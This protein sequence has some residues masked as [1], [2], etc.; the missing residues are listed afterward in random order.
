[1]RSAPSSR[2]R[3][4]SARPPSMRARILG[5]VQAL[6]EDGL[7]VSVAEALDAVAAVAAAGVDRAVLREALAATLVKDEADRPAFD[8]RFDTMFPARGA[9]PARPRK[10]RARRRSGRR[11]RRRARARGAGA[12][13]S[14]PRGEATSRIGRGRRRRRCRERT[15]AERRGEAERPSPRAARGGASSRCRSAS[16]RRSTRGGA[17]GGRELAARLRGRLARRTWRT[18]RGRLDF[19]RTIRSSIAPAACRCGLRF[20]ARRPGR[21]DLVVLCDLSRSVAEASGLLLALLAPLGRYFR[22]VELFAYV[23]RLCPVTL[24]GGHVVPDGPPRP[25]RALGPRPRAGGAGCARAACRSAARRSCLVLGDARNNRLPPRADLLRALRERVQRL[26]WLVPEPR[27][28]WDTGDSVLGLYAPSCDAVVECVNLAEL[29]RGCAVLERGS[30]SLPR[31]GPPLD[32]RARDAR[33]L[34]SADR[35]RGGGLHRRLGLAPAGAAQGPD[36]LR[37]DALRRVH[38]GTAAVARPQRRRR[39]HLITVACHEDLTGSDLVGRYLI[40]GDETVWIDGPL[41]QAVQARRHLLPRRGRRGA[42]G[43]DRPDPPADRPPPHP[44]DRQEGRDPRGAPRL[45]ARHLLQPRL[46]ERAEGPEALDPPA[47][48]HH[49]VRLPAARQGGADHRARERRRRWSTRSTLAKLGEKVRHLKAHGLEEGVS[50]RLLVYAGQLIGSGVAPRRA[51][52][53]AVSRSLTDDVESQRAIDGADGGRL[54]L[55]LQR[56]RP[57][58]HQP[59]ARGSRGRRGRARGRGARRRRARAAARRRATASPRVSP[60]LAQ[61]Y[62]RQRRGGVWAPSGRPAS[63]AG[64]RSART[65]RAASRRAATRPARSS[66]RAGGLRARAGSRPPPRGCALARRVAATSRRMAAAFLERTRGRSSR[67]PTR[68]RASRRGWR[69]GLGA[70]RGRARREP[71]AG[72]VRGAAGLVA[73]ARAGALRAPR[74]RRARAHPGGERA[75]AP[76]RAAARPRSAARPPSASA[77]PRAP[78][79]SARARRRRRIAVWRALPAALARLAP[80]VRAALV[81]VV[82]HLGPRAAAPLAETA[83]VVGALLGGGAGRRARARAR[84]GGGGGGALARGDGGGPARAAAPVRDGTA[85]RRAR[86]GSRPGSRVADGAARRGDGV[87]RARVAHERRARSRRRPP[88]PTLEDAHGVWT[89]LVQMLS[90]APATARPFEGLTLRPPLEDD[91]GARRG[92]AARCASTRSRPTRRTR[93]STACSR[94][95]SR[96]AARSGPTPIRASSPGCAT[97]SGRRSSSRSSSLAEAV[98]V[99]HRLAAVYP[100][101]ARRRARARRAPP[102]STSRASGARRQA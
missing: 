98:R 9:P 93:A 18:R 11:R 71:G 80:E 87:L 25:P 47:L 34:L 43:H 55:G 52:D 17:R 95:R 50:T 89:K 78:R 7:A 38:G 100:G 69:A 37:Q 53:V 84:A 81:R 46:P 41:T 101:F 60:L 92:G 75:R 51:C 31:R 48:R 102:R 23:D 1:M 91:P 20:R 28:R 26:V 72:V 57:V 29:V 76:R 58:A 33:A 45:P 68:R 10:G 32:S 61:R 64:W 88:R 14:P 79:R 35:R 13:R 12:G 94:R 8:A 24:E 5:F 59:R 74:R 97:R 44:A 49:R 66:R 70:P 19:R 39:R 54:R 56:A 16:T 40:E 21:P 3:S 73:G 15:A 2:P 36:R 62:Y 65:S 30:T 6:R 82:A 77:P 22:R 4:S 67:P 27:A 85:G 96:A 86:A 63:S 42:Q 90:G 83:P 99:Q